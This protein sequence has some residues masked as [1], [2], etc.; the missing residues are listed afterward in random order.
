MQTTKPSIAISSIQPK[1]TRKVTPVNNTAARDTAISI[2]K[3]TTRD[4][5]KAAIIITMVLAIISVCAIFT[6]V[7]LTCVLCGASFITSVL[8]CGVTMVILGLVAWFC[9]EYVAYRITK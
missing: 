8:V 1:N 2:K 4:K 6:G 3:T 7:A 5:D 9:V